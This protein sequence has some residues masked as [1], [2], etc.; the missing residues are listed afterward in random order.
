[1]DLFSILDEI[2][3]QAGAAALLDEVRRATPPSD[4]HTRYYL[5][6]YEGLLRFHERRY[7]LARLSYRQ[8]LGL[9]GVAKDHGTDR[10][11]RY[12]LAEIGVVLGDLDAAER[13]LAAAIA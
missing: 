10:A 7:E 11:A 8:A 6:F 1:G 2:G 3:D 12:N 5:L 9:S 13:D 4:T